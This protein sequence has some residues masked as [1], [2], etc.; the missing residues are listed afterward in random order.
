[1]RSRDVF[2]N[3]IVNGLNYN[4]RT[5]FR[6]SYIEDVNK[7][8]NPFIEIDINKEYVEIPVPML[9]SLNYVTQQADKI[10]YP[11]PTAFAQTKAKTIKTILRTFLGASFDLGNI[12]SVKTTDEDV[13]YGFPGMIFDENKDLLFCLNA[14]VKKQKPIL[15]V[16][17]VVCRISPDVFINASKIV[18][19]SIIKKLM[20]CCLSF[21]L[22]RYNIARWFT[23]T[24]KNNISVI[25]DDID[26]QRG[27]VQPSI[28]DFSQDKCMEILRRYA[29]KKYLNVDSSV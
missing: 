25:I 2:E 16:D 22:H 3:F 23:C 20:P 6:K 18:E 26:F 17:K 29:N 24:T 4:C 1:M 28:T 5:V 14:V 9:N 13:Y 7:S 11:I 27:I 21:D 12:A 8:I 10:V 19:K 15:S